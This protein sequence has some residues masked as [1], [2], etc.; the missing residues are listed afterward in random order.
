MTN[1]VMSSQ[2]EGVDVENLCVFET[3]VGEFSEI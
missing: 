1:S 2:K 3:H